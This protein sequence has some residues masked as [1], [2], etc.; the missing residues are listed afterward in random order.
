MSSIILEQR[1][2]SNPF[3]KLFRVNFRLGDNGLKPVPSAQFGATPILLCEIR[4][5]PKGLPNLKKFKKNSN[6]L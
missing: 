1:L 2:G 5:L 4:F 3:A 6:L